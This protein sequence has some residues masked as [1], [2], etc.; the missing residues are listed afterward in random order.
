MARQTTNS[1]MPIGVAGQRTSGGSAREQIDSFALSV[2]SQDG[3]IVIRDGSGGCRPLADGDT[4]TEANF[5]G[6]IVRDHFREPGASTRAANTMVPVLRAGR[7]YVLTTGAVARGNACY[8]GVAT[9]Q[10]GQIDDA[11]GTGLGAC[12]RTKFE[13]STSAA[14]IA[15]LEVG[16]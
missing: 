9:A 15:I 6:V 16:Y 1:P 5:L 3:A 2:A 13:S 10:L 7:V 12:P 11:A 14:G 4:I 8:A